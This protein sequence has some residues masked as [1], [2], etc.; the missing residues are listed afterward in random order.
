MAL[1][2]KSGILRTGGSSAGKKWKRRPL[3]LKRPSGQSSSLASILAQSTSN[4]TGAEETHGYLN[5][6]LR[7]DLRETLSPYI[8]VEYDRATNLCHMNVLGQ[9][10]MN[11]FMSYVRHYT[12]LVNDDLDTVVLRFRTWR[13]NLADEGHALRGHRWT[14]HLPPG[15]MVAVQQKRNQERLERG[16]R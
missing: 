3:L 12:G 15:V 11:H 4:S 8:T 10:S 16:R 5:A 6:T 9:C 1:R 14:T 2:T 13:N 7:Q